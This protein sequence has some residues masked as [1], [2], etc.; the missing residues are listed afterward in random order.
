MGHTGALSTVHTE[1]TDYQ[2]DR[3]NSVGHY[4]LYIQS[5]VDCPFRGHR[6]KSDRRH[7]VGHCPLYIQRALAISLGG[8][9]WVQREQ[10]TIRTGGTQW[11]TETLSVVRPDGTNNQLDR[12]YSGTLSTVHS[13]S[14]N[15]QSDKGYW[16]IV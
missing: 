7:S 2:S 12:A 11:G 3:G 6:Q 5:A 9:G 1:D 4:Q 8:G 14:T 13:E 15:N 16:D 10:K